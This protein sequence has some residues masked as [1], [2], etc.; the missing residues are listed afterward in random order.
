MKVETYCK[1]YESV[2]NFNS[3]HIHKIRSTWNIAATPDM[4]NSWAGMIQWEFKLICR[5]LY[6][7]P[8]THEAPYLINLV[9]KKTLCQVFHQVSPSLFDI[10]IQKLITFST[11]IHLLRSMDT[12]NIAWFSFMSRCIYWWKTVQLT[13][14]LLL[15]P[16]TMIYFYCVFAPQLS[17]GS[18]SKYLWIWVS[19][20]TELYF[21][22]PDLKRVCCKFEKIIGGKVKQFHH[23]VCEKGFP[24]CINGSS[25]IYK[26]S[27]FIP[28]SETQLPLW[29]AKQTKIS[30][31]TVLWDGKVFASM[32]LKRCACFIST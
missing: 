5:A 2:I 15:Y 25:H 32:V 7:E 14:W 24:A 16:L 6:F 21:V 20:G 26:D 12:V 8:G 11:L 17:N 30:Y 19:K 4:K 13:C 22:L 27:K 3:N 28:Q 9:S 29:E 18:P 10:P 31:H 23:F 1:L